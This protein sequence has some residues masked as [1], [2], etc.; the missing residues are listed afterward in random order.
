MFKN[1]V[2][3]SE[4]VRIRGSPIDSGIPVE[5]GWRW[6][7]RVV[8]TRGE[9]DH[10]RQQNKCSWKW[11]VEVVQSAALKEGAADTSKVG[12]QIAGWAGDSR[13]APGRSLRR[14]LPWALRAQEAAQQ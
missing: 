12:P 13:T 5:T 6:K 4:E 7:L 14:S 1:P 3:E 10:N 11:I 2:R 9:E 8:T